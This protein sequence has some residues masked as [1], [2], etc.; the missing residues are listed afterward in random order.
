MQIAGR[1]NMRETFSVS[2]LAVMYGMPTTFHNVMLLH[3]VLEFVC[4]SGLN[5]EDFYANA[6]QLTYKRVRLPGSLRLCCV[7]CGLYYDY[8]LTARCVDLFM[9]G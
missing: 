4:G 5:H 9:G 3:N 2:K 1:C 7:Y 6:I 8:V